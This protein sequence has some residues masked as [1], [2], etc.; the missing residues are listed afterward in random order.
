MPIFFVFSVYTELQ[1]AESSTQKQL[2][3]KGL[4]FWGYCETDNTLCYEF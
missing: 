2:S 1:K 4:Q 3:K